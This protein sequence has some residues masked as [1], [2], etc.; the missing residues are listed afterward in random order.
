MVWRDWD[1][2][3]TSTFLPVPKALMTRITDRKLLSH[4]NLN[5]PALVRL[6]RSLSRSK[7]GVLIGLLTGHYARL[8][9][10]LHRMGLASDP[11]CVA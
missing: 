10:H 1:L 6:L 8:N 11:L 3:P 5:I 4:W 9:E 7:L 2:N